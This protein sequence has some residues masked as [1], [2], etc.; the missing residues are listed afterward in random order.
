MA[1]TPWLCSVSET[2]SWNAMA[3]ALESERPNAVLRD[4][5]ARLL[6]GESGERFAGLSRPDKYAFRL[7]VRTLR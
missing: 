4:A 2:A 7:R 1:D 6:A 3:R 5:Y